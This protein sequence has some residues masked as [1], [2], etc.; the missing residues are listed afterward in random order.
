[1]P[2]IY[3]NHLTKKFSRNNTVI[4]DLNLE[5]P[6]GEFLTVIGP[7]GCGK[8]TLLRLLHIHTIR[9]QLWDTLSYKAWRLNNPEILL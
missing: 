1:M 6:Q 3:F 5:I 7:S 8:S 9:M 4:K 2:T